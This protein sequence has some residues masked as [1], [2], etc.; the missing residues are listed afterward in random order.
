MTVEE[1]SILD[2][3]YN[4]PKYTLAPNMDRPDGWL[5][6]SA[7]PDLAIKPP[8]VMRLYFC[9]H[10]A[11]LLGHQVGALVCAISRSLLHQS[12]SLLVRY[13]RKNKHILTSVFTKQ[14]A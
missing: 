5:P 7:M 1:G 13:K 3:N 12:P 14:S 10:L 8:G 9:P 6:F 4:G 11:G 2:C